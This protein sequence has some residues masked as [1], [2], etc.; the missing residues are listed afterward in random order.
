MLKELPAISRK[1]EEI[2]IMAEW[3]D[4]KKTQAIAIIDQ[5]NK[6]KVKNVNFLSIGSSSKNNRLYVN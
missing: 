6:V 5:I 4:E 3:T 2:I 1:L